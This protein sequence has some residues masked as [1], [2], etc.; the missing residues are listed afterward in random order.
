[1]T[2]SNF[3]VEKS[4]CRKKNGGLRS[5]FFFVEKSFW[6]I[7]ESTT[8]IK[9]FYRKNF[10]YRLFFVMK[11]F[12]HFLIILTNYFVATKIL[13]DDKVSS[14]MADNFGR[15]N[16]GCQNWQTKLSGVVEI[17]RQK[18]RVSKLADKISG[19]K[20]GR[21]LWQTKFRVSKLADNFGRQKFRVSKLADNFGRQNFGCQNWQTTLAD[22]N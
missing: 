12:H 18:Y 21:Q 1:M 5:Q 11:H 9:N 14:K 10:L 22:K 4:F 6:E 15:Q 8:K 3:F 17:G 16:F 7:A 19:V 2:Y 13:S 20:I